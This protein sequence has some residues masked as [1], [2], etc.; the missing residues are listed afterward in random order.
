MK[1]LLLT[2]SLSIFCF[3]VNASGDPEIGDQ[4][5]VNSPSGQYYNHVK[6]PKLN[7]L[8]KRGKLANY[9]AVEGNKVVV[10]DIETCKKGNTYVIL[11]KNDG[12]KFFGYLGAVKANYTKSLKSG[13]L[14]AI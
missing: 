7:F 12:S 8:V 5:T 1:K 11:K 3:T 6:F 14:S 2:A 13:E 10:S 4:L 9:K